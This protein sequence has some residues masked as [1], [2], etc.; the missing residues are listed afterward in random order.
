M[1]KDPIC[2]IYHYHFHTLFKHLEKS[3][4][5]PDNILSIYTHTVL[6]LIMTKYWVILLEEEECPSLLSYS[7]EYQVP[8]LCLI[9]A[10]SL[11]GVDDSISMNL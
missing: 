10:F 7:L 2:Q 1:P 4:P 3:Y 8:S 9:N 6:L 11:I 5:L